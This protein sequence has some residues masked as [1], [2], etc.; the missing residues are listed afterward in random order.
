MDEITGDVQAAIVD[1]IKRTMGVLVR[2]AMGEFGFIDEETSLRLATA[3]GEAIA[4]VQG[5]P[6]NGVYSIEPE[7]R[8]QDAFNQGRGEAV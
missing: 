6:P 8:V 2:L 7:D 1:C 5:N 3:L 4:D